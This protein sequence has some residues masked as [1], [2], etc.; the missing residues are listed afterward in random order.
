MNEA[1]VPI[2]IVGA[3]QAAARAAHA[4]RA[5]GHAGGIALV[6][7][8]PH[9]PYER[10]PLSKA[11]LQADAEP[12][13]HVLPP[14]QFQGCGLDFR[15]GVR[16]L[17]LDTAAR[18]L[19]LDD[20][21][22][23]HYGRCLLATGGVARVLP[24]LPPSTPR[25]HYLRTLDDARRLRASLQPGTRL[26]I[27]GA[28][29]IGLEVA[30]SAVQRGAQVTLV[31]TAPQL[32]GRFLPTEPADWLATQLQRQGVRLLLGRALQHAQP[33]AAQVRLTLDQDEAIEADQ[34]LV[35]IGLVPETAL[36][37]EAG[38]AIEPAN[39]GV[40]TGPD[41]RTSD[42]HV[43]AAGDC[44]SQFHPYLGATARLESWQNANEQAQA[45]A[46]GLMDQ[47]PPPAPYPWFWTD[48]GEHNLQ[49][50]GM[51][52]P[53]LRYVR[54]GD[55]AAAK[56]V[57]IGHRDGVPLHGIALNAG[58]ELRALRP[59]FEQ[60]AAFDGAAF[61]DASTAL[62]PWVKTTLAAHAARP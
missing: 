46:A 21:R 1:R 53:G 10:P 58:T 17:R 37:R 29:F 11:V 33:G 31:E 32:L 51:A 15:P 27:V 39:G 59:L 2:V 35:A 14:E 38:L 13:L 57:W 47:A 55:P 40:R 5:L 3:G 34:V 22:V 25:V 8:E 44:A 16:A 62:R 12:A 41:G 19:Q 61:A 28:G 60:K 24:A 30:A 50:L 48:Q 9:P 43:Y 4:L 52:Q 49:M 42:P 36:A 26:A 18:L 6:G 7:A 54:R 45:A 20:G 23:L 56:A